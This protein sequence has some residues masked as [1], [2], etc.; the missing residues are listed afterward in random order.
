MWQKLL[1]IAFNTFREAIR[2]RV[3]HAVI[4]LSFVLVLSSLAIGELSVENNARVI[5]NMGMTFLNFT[6]VFVSIFSGVSLLQIELQRK[7]IYTIVTKSVSREMVIVGKFMGLVG[8]LLCV[9]LIVS[10]VLLGI[11]LMR[12]EN[13]PLSLIQGLL[14]MF[15]EGV[16]VAGVATLFSSFSTPI[17]SGVL[18]FGIFVL[19]RLRADLYLY[20]EKMDQETLAMLIKSLGV[21]IPD[22]VLLRTDLEV[23]Y[24]IS[25]SWSYVGYSVAYSA[26]YALICIALASFIFSRR[27][28]V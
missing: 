16:I 28:F 14:L 17:L 21:V 26:L 7:T 6:V 8:T 23:A 1:A 27:D 5:R 10:L 22:L 11:I 24:E 2:N 19:G 20:A 25:L 9:Q 4:V 18:T 13:L 12:G 15:F 3:L